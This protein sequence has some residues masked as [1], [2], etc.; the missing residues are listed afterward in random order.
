MTAGRFPHRIY[1]ITTYTH[2][3]YIKKILQ[4]QLHDLSRI[5]QHKQRFSH[6]KV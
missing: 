4:I 1:C 2:C 6:R 3:N 5:Q